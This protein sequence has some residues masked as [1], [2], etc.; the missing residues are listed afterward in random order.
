MLLPSIVEFNYFGHTM[1]GVSINAVAQNSE[2]SWLVN[3]SIPAG[4]PA[5][6]SN[7]RIV[8]AA[9]LGATGN[10]KLIPFQT[11]YYFSYRSGTIFEQNASITCTGSVSYQTV[12]TA[13]TIE[14]NQYILITYYIT[15][16][17]LNLSILG[18]HVDH[19]AGSR[20]MVVA[21]SGAQGG[22]ADDTYSI[23]IERKQI[24]RLSDLA[25]A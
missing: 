3:D 2:L 13:T 10:F 16:N 4:V 22:P 7:M 9:I 14:T 15:K 11:I 5:L 17:G 12:R 25:I 19:D 20:N 18:R 24:A 21:I 8:P 6:G 1:P 23:T